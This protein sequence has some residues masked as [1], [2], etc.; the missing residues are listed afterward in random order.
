LLLAQI[1]VIYTLLLYIN[2]A[3]RLLSLFRYY[4]YINVDPRPISCTLEKLEWD[5]ILYLIIEN[6]P[7]ALIL[8]NIVFLF[9]F[10]PATTDSNLVCSIK[11]K[12]Q[13]KNLNYY[14]MPESILIVLRKRLLFLCLFTILVWLF[15]FTAFTFN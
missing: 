12:H 13:F 3:S 11:F 4:T 7:I 14:S 15:I 5:D 2:N 1:M 9:F 10:F 6:T 8:A